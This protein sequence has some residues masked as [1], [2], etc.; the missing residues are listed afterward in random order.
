MKQLFLVLFT[1]IIWTPQAL[2]ETDLDRAS[3]DACKCLK[4]PYQQLEKTA[5]A[6]K[7]AQKTGDMSQ[8]QSSQT[9]LI[10]LLKASTACFENLSKEYPDIDQSDELKRKVMEKTQQMCPAPVLG[11]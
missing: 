3:S 5:S 4:A 8:M 9:E 2:S 6:I 11:Y 10:E 1:C 7:K